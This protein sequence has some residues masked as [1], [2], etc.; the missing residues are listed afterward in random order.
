MPTAFRF[1]PAAVRWSP[2]L[3][4]LLTKPSQVA[5]G[6]SL[7]PTERFLR[8]FNKD[9]GAVVWEERMTL[10]PMGTPMTY[11]YKGRQYI[12]VAAGGAGEPA[13]LVAYALPE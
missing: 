3:C 7:S 13:E 4:C 6:F 9:T 10:A 8:A 2:K 1:S 12:V 11:V 5:L